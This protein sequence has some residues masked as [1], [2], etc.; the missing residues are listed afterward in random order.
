MMVLL[1][2]WHTLHTC[3]PGRVSSPHCEPG[4][5]E[6]CRK[7]DADAPSASFVWKWTVSMCVGT[8]YIRAGV[9][10]STCASHGWASLRTQSS[11]H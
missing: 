6:E 1:L 4:Q 8:W 5:D 3:S 10:T 9:P 11:T 2:L 7:P